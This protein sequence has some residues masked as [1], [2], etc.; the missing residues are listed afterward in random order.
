MNENGALRS[1]LLLDDDHAL[2]RLQRPA[3]L[4]GLGALAL[5]L[6]GAIFAPQQ[7][8]RSYLIAYLFWCG[9]AL[10]SLAIL[11]LQHITG[12][13]W[14]AVIR[15][16]LESATRT[17]PLLALLFLPLVFGLSHLYEWAQPEHVAHDEILQHK[18]IYLNVPFFLARAAL[19]FG[20]WLLLARFLNRWSLEQDS[21]PQEQQGVRLEYLSRG[22]LLLYSLTM[23]FASID[24]VMSLEPHW[25]ST[26]YGL[27]FVGGQVLSAFA[28]VIPILMLLTDRPPMSEIVSADQFQ[29]LGKLLLAFIMLWAY[30][31]FSQFLIIWAGNLPEETPWYVN[32]L[33]G[34]WQWIGVA[35]IVLHFAL[36]FGILLSRDLKRNARLLSMVAIGVVS[37][38][39]V[40]LYWLVTPAFSPRALSVH[41]L[42]LATL[43]GVGGVWL[44]FFVNQLK[45]RPL[46]PLQDPSLPLEVSA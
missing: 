33:H 26:I 42:D 25:F 29:D 43:V 30:F 12:G 27:L 23:T 9:I 13:A 31:S 21:I 18:A 16:V 3:L 22:G 15:R 14:G 4:G 20:V 19:Y 2:V 6:I 11:M 5:G 39:F 40:D 44:A 45:G 32:R 36:P 35:Q 24:W 34:G 38:R 37:M 10:G 7:F 46:L 28:F 8:F 41:W 1:K 17:L